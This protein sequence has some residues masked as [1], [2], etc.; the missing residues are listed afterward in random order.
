MDVFNC[1]EVLLANSDFENNSGT[2]IVLKSYRGNAGGVA[3]GINSASAS[4]LSSPSVQISNCTFVNNSALATSK[5]HTISQTA[6]NLIFTGRGGGLGVF[7]NESFFN[8]SLE[9]SDCTFENNFARSFGGGIYILLNGRTAQHITTVERTSFLSNVAQLHGGGGM[10]LSYLSN[11]IPGSPHTTNF[12]DCT[13]QNNRAEG[14][15]GIYVFTS[16][17]GTAM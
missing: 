15:G 9:I 5:F 14:G 2:G 3:I 6:F 16:F 1:Q 8:V 12:T 11:G 13:F 17:Q 7:V 4:F 10:Q